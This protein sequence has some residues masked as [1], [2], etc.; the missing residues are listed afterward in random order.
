MK[1]LLLSVALAATPVLPIVAHADSASSPPGPEE[2]T[3]APMPLDLALTKKLPVPEPL[4]SVQKV[5]GTPG[6][7]YTPEGT[8]KMPNEVWY[9]WY[10]DCGDRM[11]FGDA[12]VS[13]GQVMTLWFQGCAGETIVREASSGDFHVVD[14]H[15][16]ITQLA[17]TPKEQAFRENLSKK[18]AAED[19]RFRS[20]VGV[21]CAMMAID[22]EAIAEEHLD[23]PDE[24]R[25]ELA[26]RYVA[27]AL[28]D[29]HAMG[30]DMSAA[31]LTQIAGQFVD[32][33]ED[34]SDL[35]PKQLKKQFTTDCTS[36]NLPW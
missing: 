22:V 33:V 25:D 34:H 5:I 14:A 20:A 15:G 1:R 18:E 10:H 29:V 36:R 16:K 24:S 11:S 17:E 23:Y 4:A 21:P 13:G 31:K 12:I 30:Q 26:A 28:P 35:A 8:T 19:Q 27:A 3:T 9:R 6:D 2:D 32:Y 7:A